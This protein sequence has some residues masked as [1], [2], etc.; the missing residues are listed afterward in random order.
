[1]R[2][3]IT[4]SREFGSGGRELGKYLAESLGVAYYD[5]EIVTA[6][7]ERSGF[8]REYVEGISEKGVSRRYPVTYARSF[9][10]MPCFD[11]M[12][13]GILSEQSKLLQ[14]IAEKDDCVIVGRCADIVL[15]DYSPLNLFVYADMES[16][17]KRCMDRETD[18]ER[19]E[20]KEVH[21]RILSIDKASSLYRGFFAS[22]KWGDKSSYHL[23]INTTGLEIKSLVPSVKAF[24]DCFFAAR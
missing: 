9:S 6:I 5:R 23:C 20:K 24:A 15:K 18:G 12:Q 10:Y 14:E 11:K 19:L 3:I 16:K 1:M 7:V 8:S 17:I 22:G 4:V 2:K 13:L 21:K